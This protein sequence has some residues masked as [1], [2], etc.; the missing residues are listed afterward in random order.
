MKKIIVT[1]GSGF[2]GKHLVTSLIEKGHTVTSIQRKDNKDDDINIQKKIVDLATYNPEK[3]GFTAGFE[4]IIHLA[5]NI[6]VGDMI[7]NPKENIMNNLLSTLNVLE[8]IRLNNKDCMLIFASSEKVY[9]NPEETPV[10]EDALCEPADPYGSSKLI[11]ETLIKSYHTSYG[12]NH[13]I[14]RSG[15]TFGP[16]QGRGLFI[17]SMITRIT[18][19]ETKLTLGNLEPYRNFVYV[20]DLIEAFINSIDNKAALNNTFNIA[21]Y[22]LQMSDV[23][24]EITGLSLNILEKEIDIVQDKALFRKSEKDSKRF[25]LDCSKAEKVLG[26]KPKYQFSEAMKMTFNS[27]LH[28]GPTDLSEGI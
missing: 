7:N 20:T 15:N 6:N 13:I 25:F 28:Q 3:E 21:S 27:Y 18:N 12:I 16:G 17:P 26:W 24:S 23:L 14:F 5:A 8:D 22:N 19:G 11:S 4:I 9:G 10:T 2:I 1:G